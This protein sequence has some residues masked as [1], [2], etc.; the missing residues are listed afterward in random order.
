MSTNPKQR[1]SIAV[2]ELFYKLSITTIKQTS[3]SD[4]V[5]VCCY[6]FF[7]IKLIFILPILLHFDFDLSDIHLHSHILPCL[8]KRQT[9]FSFKFI[10]CLVNSEEFN[11]FKKMFC[12]YRVL[13]LI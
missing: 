8:F 6:F 2:M 11:H 1:R 5:T 4:D 13:Q 12:L 10:V 9:E 7:K 3:I